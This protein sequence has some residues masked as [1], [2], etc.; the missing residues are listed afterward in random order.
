MRI[1][2][3]TQ[4]GPHLWACLG[5]VPPFGGA[6]S[7]TKLYNG[8]MADGVMCGCLMMTGVGGEAPGR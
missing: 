8:L 6:I 4:Q 1:G 3:A 2:A 5:I 7:I